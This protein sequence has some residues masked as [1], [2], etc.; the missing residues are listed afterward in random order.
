M[1]NTVLIF[2]KITSNRLIYTC[3]LI[4][5]EHLGLDFKITSDFEEYVDY[6]NAKLLYTQASNR[7]DI[8]IIPNSL[9]FEKNIEKKQIETCLFN[10]MTVPFAT[11][12]QPFPFDVF[13]AIF[14]MISRY[15]EYL[16]FEKNQYGQFKATDSLAS[17]LGFL[18]KP[19]VDIW[20]QQLKDVLK[21]WYPQ[22]IFKEKK[23]STTFTYDIDVAYAY[24]GRGILVNSGN[25]LKDIFTFKFRQIKERHAVLSKRIKDPFDTYTH[26]MEQKKSNGHKLL[27]FFLLGPKNKFNRN[28]LPSN[29]VLQHLIAEIAEKENIGIHPSYFTDT[30]YSL[31]QK[32]K[33][34]M[35]FISRKKIVSSR[36]HY[37]KLAFPETYSNLIKSGITDDYTLAFA[38]L[39]GFRAGTCTSFSFYNLLTD[40]ETRLRIHPNTFMEGTFIEDLKMNPDE[41]FPV[42]KKLINE[43]KKVN[44]HFL[45]IWHN[46]TLSN[47]NEW[48]GFK[49]VHDAIAAYASE[50]P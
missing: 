15:E 11:N 44:G 50:R 23:F 9:L 47:K 43:I 13:A 41:T 45:S 6:P 49:A 1:N 8:H 27:F 2:S 17:Q 31:L 42:M 34:L 7:T 39:P 35:E 29:K 12:G 25:F 22:L 10:G 46:H 18:Q 30:D 3:K 38:E 16:P 28:L 4:F 26:I 37:L 21:G 24:L 14:Y 20:I 48:E 36:Q 40:E 32:E 5:K 33:K 19:V